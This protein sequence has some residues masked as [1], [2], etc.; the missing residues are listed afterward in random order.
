MHRYILDVKMMEM[1][2]PGMSFIDE[3]SR[4]HKKTG[5]GED[6]SDVRMVL[7]GTIPSFRHGRLHILTVS[8][9]FSRAGISLR[10]N[11]LATECLRLSDRAKS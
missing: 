6:A 5:S 3:R 4:G 2:W 9:T 10:Q 7:I 8:L 1:F 11:L